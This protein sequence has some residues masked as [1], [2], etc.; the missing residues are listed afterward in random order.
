MQHHAAQSLAH[1]C[2]GLSRKAEGL[3]GRRNAD[4]SSSV[5]AWP[6]IEV[7]LACTL[8]GR[9]SGCWTARL[10]VAE[11]SCTESLSSKTPTLNKQVSSYG[12]Q[13]PNPPNP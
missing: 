5:V 1:N 9:S 11:L 13:Y 12:G 7:A 2:C 4:A 10:K 8:V 6:T 3:F